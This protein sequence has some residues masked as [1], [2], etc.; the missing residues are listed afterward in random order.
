MECTAILVIILFIISMFTPFECTAN[1]N[2][3]IVT[4]YKIFQWAL[5]ASK[6]SNDG[7]VYWRNIWTQLVPNSLLCRL[8]SARRN[9]DLA[10][11]QVYVFWHQLPWSILFSLILVSSRQY[12]YS[13]TTRSGSPLVTEWRQSWVSLELFLLTWLHKFSSLCGVGWHTLLLRNSKKS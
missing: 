8:P 10:L 9:A 13:T 4:Y 11:G 5:D 3:C 2:C 12:L 7:A 1:H 6:N